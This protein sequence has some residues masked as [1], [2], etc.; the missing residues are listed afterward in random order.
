M[1]VH[2]SEEE[3]LEVMKRWW[4]DYGRTVVIAVLVAVIGYFGYTT[5][6]DQK[7][8]TAEKASM[9]YEE[10]LK[11]VTVEPGKVIADADKATVTH[12]AGQLKEI[13]SKSKFKILL[14]FGN[15]EKG[16]SLLRLASSLV[17]KQK[18]NVV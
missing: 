6:Q 11:L 12:L 17:K 5:W 14:F 4:K 2:L 3:Q 1:S 16:K 18:E 13:N 10:L 9:I 7:R 8:Q 15:N